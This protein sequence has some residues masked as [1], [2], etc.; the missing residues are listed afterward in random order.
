MMQS[1]DDIYSG[2]TVLALI[3]IPYG[4]AECRIPR[5][6]LGGREVSFRGRGFKKSDWQKTLNQKYLKAAFSMAQSESMVNL[7]VRR[8]FEQG[9]GGLLL[10]T[11]NSDLKF[12]W[13]LV[14]EIRK[15]VAALSG[16]ALGL[17]VS[18]FSDMCEASL[19]QDEFP[20]MMKNVD[21]A[22]LIF[23]VRRSEIIRD[24]SV[25]VRGEIFV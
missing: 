9:T 3:H 17:Y 12:N 15:D 8:K 20:V 25:I 5:S 18:I 11:D 10:Y 16:K 4:V 6:D 2:D 23:I 19:G 13:L 24:P 21:G 1:L 7:G 14:D 22:D